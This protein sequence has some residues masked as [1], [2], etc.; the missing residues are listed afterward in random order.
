MDFNAIDCIYT[1]LRKSQK[2]FAAT[3]QTAPE[4][5]GVKQLRESVMHS[6]VI[7]DKLRM[8][9]RGF[10]HPISSAGFPRLTTLQFACTSS[11][12]ARPKHG[13][14]RRVQAGGRAFERHTCR[15]PFVNHYFAAESHILLKNLKNQLLYALNRNTSTE[16][17]GLKSRGYTE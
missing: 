12:R 11:A 15:S 14:R 4:C 8:A 2:C 6:A 7:A 13:G 10:G 17:H 5:W 3:E 1:W 9:G 16:A